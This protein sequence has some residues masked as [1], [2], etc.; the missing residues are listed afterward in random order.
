VSIS[1]IEV[2]NLPW[3]P[4]RS[5]AA[6]GPVHILLDDGRE[7]H[8]RAGLGPGY[9]RRIHADLEKKLGNPVPMEVWPDHI[10]S[11]MEAS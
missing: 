7:F 8:L 2:V 6:D 9:W 11:V 4:P 5:L 3:E 1:I 10:R